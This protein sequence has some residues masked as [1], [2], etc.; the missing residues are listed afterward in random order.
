MRTHVVF[1]CAFAFAP[2]FCPTSRRLYNTIVVYLLHLFLCFPSWWSHGNLRFRNIRCSCGAARE[3]IKI[4]I[5]LVDKLVDFNIDEEFLTKK[6]LKKLM[7]SFD[8]PYLQ[9]PRV[10]G[11]RFVGTESEECSEYDKVNIAKNIS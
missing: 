11:D 1:M 9:F 6:L 2:S 5:F 7:F 8:R 3:H 4:R 10:L